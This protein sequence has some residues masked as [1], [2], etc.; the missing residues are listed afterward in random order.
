MLYRIALNQYG[1]K[2]CVDRVRYTKIQ[3]NRTVAFF[4]ADHLGPPFSKFTDAIK[5]M[6]AVHNLLERVELQSQ[7]MGD[8]NEHPS[9]R[10]QSKSAYDSLVRELTALTGVVP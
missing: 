6:T 1:D 10:A 2:W 5:H 8:M 7:V 9:L 3:T 4:I